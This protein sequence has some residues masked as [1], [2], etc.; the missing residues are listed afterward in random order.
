MDGKVLRI[1]ESRAYYSVTITSPDESYTDILGD[2]LVLTES[3]L[4][5]VNGI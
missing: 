4:R 1:D 2:W 5:Y 3:T